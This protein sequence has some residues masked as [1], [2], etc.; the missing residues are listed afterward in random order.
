MKKKY[1]NVNEEVSRIKELFTEERLFG[2]LITEAQPVNPKF[3]KKIFTDIQNIYD[4]LKK[5]VEIDDSVKTGIFNKISIFK[6]SINNLH[7]KFKNFNEGIN[8]LDPKN[9]NNI[10][11]IISDEYKKIF[12]GVNPSL[13]IKNN[14]GILVNFKT[15]SET[16]ISKIYKSYNEINKEF[17]DKINEVIIKKSK[18]PDE[19]EKLINDVYPQYGTKLKKI[20]NPLIYKI[21][22]VIKNIIVQLKNKYKNFLLKLKKIISNPYFT[23]ATPFNYLIKK[24][25]N[26][27]DPSTYWIIYDLLAFRYIKAKI[28]NFYCKY[29]Y[30][31]E[32]KLKLNEQKDVDYISIEDTIITTTIESVLGLFSPLD[33]FTV[34]CTN[35]STAKEQLEKD[36]QDLFSTLTELGF[37]KSTIEEINKNIDNN[38][39]KLDVNMVQLDTIVSDSKKLV[40]QY[41]SYIDT[42]TPE[43]KQD[44]INKLHLQIK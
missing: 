33:W 34:T 21:I 22:D 27:N 31:P 42:L 30:L 10:S 3:Y 24:N 25:I 12:E 35:L 43:Q 14:E 37:N 15:F 8:L 18:F 2:N 38:I 26:K 4:L 1:I 19:L 7:S 5:N 41:N 13:R 16:E 44:L 40:S 17:Y 9:E 23:I 28:S 29:I 11:K 32:S 6:N 39:K 20:Y 36:K